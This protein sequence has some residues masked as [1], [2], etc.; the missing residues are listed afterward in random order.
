VTTLSAERQ[1]LGLGAT[2]AAGSVGRML[3]ELRRRGVADD[4]VV[5]QAA[6]Q[7]WIDAKVLEVMGE[8]V[9]AGVAAGGA[10]A[11]LAAIRLSRRSDEFLDSLRG[12]DAMLVDDWTLFQ[13]WIPATRI[14]G[15]TEEALR[16][17]VAE[18]VLG[19]PKSPRQERTGDPFLPN[20]AVRGTGS[21]GEGEA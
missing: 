14:G 16:S 2:G 4:P 3:A 9:L 11:R 15:G 18:R 8:R 1:A 10:V 13:L 20:R 21:P 5:Q 19:L 17:I 6:A 7:L 12:A